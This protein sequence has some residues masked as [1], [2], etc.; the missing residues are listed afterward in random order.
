MTFDT[1]TVYFIGGPDD[2]A[3]RV[4]HGEKPARDWLV[5]ASVATAQHAEGPQDVAHAQC[6][7]HEYRLVQLPNLQPHNAPR[8]FAA[9]Y[10]GILR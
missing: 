4:Y 7:R 9:V 3:K 1:H 6:T 5:T 10:R 2:Q 8:T